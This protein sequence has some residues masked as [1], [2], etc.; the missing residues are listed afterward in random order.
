[1]QRRIICALAALLATV[2]AAGEV[3]RWTDDQG[4]T[5]ISDRPPPP[6]TRG[7]T[8]QEL[9]PESPTP[10]ER[11]AA[12]ERIQRDRAHAAALEDERRSKDAAAQPVP[13]RAAA[14]APAPG[15]AEDCRA[16][17]AAYYRSHDC[18]G[19]YIGVNGIKGEAHAACGPQLR[20]PG[21]SGCKPLSRP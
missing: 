9:R 15:S 3:Y 18:Y 2:A 10:E 6:G 21:A 17:W 5:Q 14:S 4:R 19:R 1:M 13:V 20:D 16:R 12:Q 8:R 7:A 11:R